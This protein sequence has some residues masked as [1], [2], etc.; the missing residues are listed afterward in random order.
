MS[1]A[2]V[3][4]ALTT[5]LAPAQRFVLVTLAAHVNHKRPDKGAWPSVATLARET[6]YSDRSVQK[7]LRALEADGHISRLPPV[8][9]SNRFLVHPQTVRHLTGLEQ[10]TRPPAGPN[11]SELASP[12][13]RRSFTPNPEGASPKQEETKKEKGRL[14]DAWRGGARSIGEVLSTSA[15]DVCRKAITDFADQNPTAAKPS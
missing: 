11:S 15:N 9:R 12:Q 14:S 7:A 8:G 1:I 13:P 6:G 3:K 2:L 4:D 5:N 10:S